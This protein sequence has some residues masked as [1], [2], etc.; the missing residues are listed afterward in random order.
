MTLVLTHFSVADNHH[1]I[2]I[3]DP[4]NRLNTFHGMGIIACVTIT[5]KYWLQAIRRTTIK[6]SGIAETA[7]IEQKILQFFRDTKTLKDV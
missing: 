6:S 5:K 4:T 1:G 7:K 3:V 2:T